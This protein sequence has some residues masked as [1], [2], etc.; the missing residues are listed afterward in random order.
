MPT[1]HLHKRIMR[2]Q[3]RLKSKLDAAGWRLY[4]DLENA[5]NER[6]AALL[7]YIQRRLALDGKQRSRA[8]QSSRTR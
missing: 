2:L 3:H 1:R 8:Q 6:Q 4:L 7:D 5:V